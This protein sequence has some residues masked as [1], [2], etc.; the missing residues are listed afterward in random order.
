MPRNSKEIIFQRKVAALVKRAQH[1][2]DAEVKKVI[3]LLAEARKSVAATVASTDWQAFYLPQ[4]QLA[5]ERALE[6]FGMRYGVD[7]RDAQLSF[8]TEGVAFVDLP[9]ASVG[10]TAALPAVDTTVLGIIQGYGAGLVKGLSRS[11]AQQ[12]NNELA[13]GL[14]GQKAPFD[15][16]Q[17]VG[18]NLKDASIFKSIAAR[19]ETITRTECGRALSA[20]SQARFEAAAAVV[21]GLKKRW[22]YGAARR[23]QPRYQHLGI[24]GQ[25]R[26]VDQPFGVA[27]EALMYPRDPAGSAGNTINCQCYSTPWLASFAAAA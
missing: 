9:L 26:D 10:I 20:A 27:G 22:T 1:L 23:R 17:A 25:V 16:M 4:M 8:W 11:A 13:L 2:E 24:D 12:I 21:P 3:L 5:I 6:E 18:R 7:L 15:V 19:A 14:M